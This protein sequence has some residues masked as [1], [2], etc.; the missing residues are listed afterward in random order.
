LPIY[1][2]S[3]DIHEEEGIR[4]KEIGVKNG[5]IEIEWNKYVK[6]QNINYS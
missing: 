1:F 2:H 3:K 5:L 6:H 4:L